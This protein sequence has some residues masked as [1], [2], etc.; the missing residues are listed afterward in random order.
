MCRAMGGG[1]AGK[2]RGSAARPW[3]L[4]GLLLRLFQIDRTVALS[5]PQ[6]HQQRRRL[7]PLL[8]GACV[9]QTVRAHAM[10]SAVQHD[11]MASP[12]QHIR[13][14]HTVGGML[15][16]APAPPRRLAFNYLDDLY[17]EFMDKFRSDIET[18]SRPY[19]F[20]SGARPGEE[21][22]YFGR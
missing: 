20:V 17:K 5:L 16:P 21:W 14:L 3:D 9:S 7:L 6:L 12:S 2:A 19:A 1:R 15:S 10:R 13:R 22:P 18:A 8:D 11:R 4:S